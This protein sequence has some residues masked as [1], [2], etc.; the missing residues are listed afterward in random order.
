MF[1]FIALALLGL[2]AAVA[3]DGWI[4]LFNGKDFTGWKVS[5]HESSFSIKDGAIVAH[6]ERAHCFYVGDAAKHNF[7]NFEL[8]VDVKAGPGS[9]GGI[10][11]HTE[12]QDSGWP[13]KGFEV[14]VNNTYNRDPVKTGSLYHVKDVREALPE[15]DEWFT[16]HIV[17]RGNTVTISVN[18]KE[19][20]SWTQPADW[21]GTSEFVGRR[22]GSGTIAL[23]GHDPGSTVAYKNIQ[24]KLLP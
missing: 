17:V 22:I 10:F 8:K 18:G 9:N 20:A 3:Q 6:G 11:F 7:K 13:A 24:I 12:Y 1:R 19:T 16:E 4:S 23:Q 5:E 15:D 21:N 14:Q 2:S